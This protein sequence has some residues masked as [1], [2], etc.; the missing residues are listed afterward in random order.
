MSKCV[1]V[2]NIEIDNAERPAIDGM[3][4]A[5]TISVMNWIKLGETCIEQRLVCI[6][7]Q[8]NSQLKVFYWFEKHAGQFIWHLS[9]CLSVP[10]G[11][12]HV[13]YFLYVVLVDGYNPSNVSDMKVDMYPDYVKDL[14]CMKT[15]GYGYTEYM[16]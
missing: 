9:H 11:N 15:F 1:R 5:N 6:L 3:D 14:Y 2:A 4:R 8:A 10:E 12:L 7:P 13:S 16:Q